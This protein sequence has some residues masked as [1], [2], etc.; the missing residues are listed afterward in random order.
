V[1]GVRES[2]IVHVRCIDSCSPGIH[3]HRPAGSQLARAARASWCCLARILI[4]CPAS[5]DAD[6]HA[7]SRNSR[8]RFFAAPDVQIAW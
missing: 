3:R 8:R 6:R 4:E 5:L 2:D 1:A 7:R